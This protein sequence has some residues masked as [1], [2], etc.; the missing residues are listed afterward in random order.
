MGQRAGGGILGGTSARAPAFLE[1]AS[2]GAGG[3]FR[4]EAR[5]GGVNWGSSRE[6]EGRVASSWSIGEGG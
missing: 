2:A 3:G 1:T 6:G 5:G 4:A